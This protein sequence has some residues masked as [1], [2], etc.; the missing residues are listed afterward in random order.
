[1][2]FDMRNFNEN[3]FFESQRKLKFVVGQSDWLST[4]WLSNSF[5][6]VEWSS[7]DFASS[8][9]WVLSDFSANSSS[10]SSGSL[11]MSIQLEYVGDCSPFN[12]VECFRFSSGL[13]VLESSS[14]DK[15]MRLKGNEKRNGKLGLLWKGIYE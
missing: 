9:F 14:S 15:R 10:K 13:S 7:L 12:F 4:Q 1:M 11:S 3:G 8:E 2:S 6:V 5:G